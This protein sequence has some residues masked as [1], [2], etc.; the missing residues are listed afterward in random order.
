VEYETNSG[1]PEAERT[2]AP[3]GRTRG[4]WRLEQPDGVAEADPLRLHGLGYGASSNQTALRRQTPCDC[5]VW[6]DPRSRRCEG[7]HSTEM[8]VPRLN[9]T[10]TPDEIAP[11]WSDFARRDEL[12]GVISSRM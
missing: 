2:G 5:T 3:G 12:P 9:P 11:F 1:F 8:V 10:S 6:A 4:L 7:A